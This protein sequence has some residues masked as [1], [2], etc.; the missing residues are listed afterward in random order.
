MTPKTERLTVPDK[1]RIVRRDARRP[2]RAG[3]CFEQVPPPRHNVLAPL[4]GSWL[5]P[6]V[7]AYS[8]LSGVTRA[9]GDV[10]KR[11]DWAV[12]AEFELRHYPSNIAAAA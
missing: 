10:G 11:V 3:G 8:T 7:S 9:R 1:V 6:Q 12:R 2:P 5:F 4:L